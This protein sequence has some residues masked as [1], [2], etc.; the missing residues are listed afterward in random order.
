MIALLL[1]SFVVGNKASA[2]PGCEVCIAPSLCYILTFDLPNCPGNRAVFCYQCGVTAPWIHVDITEL[3]TC[4]GYEDQAWDYVY[5]WVR[6]NIDELCIS[7]SCD[8]PPPMEVYITRPIC[9]EVKC[10]GTPRRLTYKAHPGTCDRRCYSKYLWCRDYS[11][12]PPTTYFEATE[13]Y[14]VGNGTCN[15]PPYGGYGCID[16]EPPW[17][18]ECGGVPGVNCVLQYG[19]CN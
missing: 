15:F 13:C 19:R 7:K 3:T 16:S 6:D 5:Q 10:E 9:A 8:D 11:S 1:F 17:R 18:L 14:P 2:Q 12:N 4:P